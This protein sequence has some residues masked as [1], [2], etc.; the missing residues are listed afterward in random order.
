MATDHGQVAGVEVNGMNLKKCPFC[1]SYKIYVNKNYSGKT[2]TFFYFVKCDIC[3]GTGGSAGLPKYFEITDENEWNN[4]A[5]DRAVA[6]W[7][8]REGC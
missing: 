8:N 3:G 1:G 2:N 5:C 4:D 6:K 7:N